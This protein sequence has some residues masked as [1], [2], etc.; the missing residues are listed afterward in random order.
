MIYIDPANKPDDK[1]VNKVLAAYVAADLFFV[2][3][4]AVMVGFSVIV[5]NTMYD[6][7]ND[8]YQVVRNLLFQ[9][10]PLTGMSHPEK[11]LL[12]PPCGHNEN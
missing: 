5:K 1:M 10:F 2:A 8:G 6:T 11:G 7:T 9:Q 3:T 12:S 4:G